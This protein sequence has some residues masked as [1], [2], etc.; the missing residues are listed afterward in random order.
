MWPMLIKSLSFKGL[1]VHSTLSIPVT[2]AVLGGSVN[3]S[4]IYGDI[5][6]NM[7]S[8]IA[9][10]S[11]YKINKFGIPDVHDKEKVGDHCLKIK[12]TMPNS[13]NEKQKILWREFSKSDITQHL[14]KF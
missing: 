4:T 5:N 11:E 2:R 6:W 14:H 12:Y 1:D 10:D 3:V 9:P 7:P 13:L 8:W